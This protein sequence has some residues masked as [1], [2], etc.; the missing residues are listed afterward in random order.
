MEGKA[1]RYKTA[2]G[3]DKNRINGVE[4]PG[5]TGKAFSAVLAALLLSLFST[6]CTWK[7]VPNIFA[8]QIPPDPCDATNSAYLGDKHFLDRRF[9]KDDGTLDRKALRKT[10][11]PA[12][13]PCD[14]LQQEKQ[15]YPS[16][17]K[18]LVEPLDRT[19][20]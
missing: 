12:S 15:Y 17:F 1:F 7:D 6:S 9:L 13:S 2:W 4:G 14:P 18:T 5:L 16:E 19:I 3:K 8:E 11:D 20:R 10:L